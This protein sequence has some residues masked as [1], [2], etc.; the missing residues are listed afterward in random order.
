MVRSRVTSS[1]GGYS[2]TPVIA[3]TMVIVPNMCVQSLE[4]PYEASSRGDKILL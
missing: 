3:V 1:M 2:L 4:G